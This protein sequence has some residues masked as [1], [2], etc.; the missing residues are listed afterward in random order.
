MSAGGLETFRSTAERALSAG[1]LH[2]TMGSRLWDTYR[3]TLAQ[4]SHPCAHAAADKAKVVSCDKPLTGRHLA[5]Y[6][7]W[8]MSLLAAGAGGDK[9]SERVRSVFH[10][11]LQ[12]PLEQ[13]PATM[14][15]YNDWTPDG[16]VTTVGRALTEAPVSV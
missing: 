7:A 16:E 12:V 13:G 8:E 1:G 6:R 9:Q 5:M 4:H 3:C 15:A 14:A 10:R 2:V 11:Q